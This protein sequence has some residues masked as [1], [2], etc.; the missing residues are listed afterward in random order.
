MR[1]SRSHRTAHPDGDAAP[2]AD[3][4][5]Y[6]DVVLA[7]LVVNALARRTRV[8]EQDVFRRLTHAR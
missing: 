3:V 2:D 8:A 4:S 1:S 7:E 6:A 5:G